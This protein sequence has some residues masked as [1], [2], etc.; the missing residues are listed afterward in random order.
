MI[1]LLRD[2]LCR[3]GERLF[4]LKGIRAGSRLIEA[5]PGRVRRTPMVVA[6]PF[7]PLPDSP[8][9]YRATLSSQFRKNL[10]VA[11]KRL[12]AE[13]VRSEEHTSELQSL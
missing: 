6:A 1:S 4:D 13:G 3:P 7:T 9:A 12:T 8:Q 11:A 10:R 2:W 5:L